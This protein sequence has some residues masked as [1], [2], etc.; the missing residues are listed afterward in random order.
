MVTIMLR[1]RSRIVPLNILVLF[2]C[3]VEF[4][5]L[6][7]YPRPRNYIT[8]RSFL[9]KIISIFMM[10]PNLIKR[11][12]DAQKLHGPGTRTRI[13]RVGPNP[14]R[15]RV[16]H[17][18]TNISKSGFRGGPG[19]DRENTVRSGLDPILINLFR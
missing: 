11:S 4:D 7:I 1:K 13:F 17:R 19:P 8:S 18:I 3:R 5:L 10:L 12:R 16:G 14:D 9:L 15:Y 6:H 2:Y